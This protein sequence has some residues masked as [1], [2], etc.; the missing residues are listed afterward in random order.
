M[1]CLTHYEHERLI[2]AMMTSATRYNSSESRVE[3]DVSLAKNMSGQ[4]ATDFK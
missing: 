2:S 4:N 3:S 1:V